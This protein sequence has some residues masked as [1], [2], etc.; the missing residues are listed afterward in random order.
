VIIT[1]NEEQNIRDALES[2]KDFSEIVAIDSFSSDKTV[3][4]SKKY[5]EKVYE[6]ERIDT[7]T[8]L[9]L[10]YFLKYAEAWERE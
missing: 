2:V 10:L 6:E 5:T 7:S 4:I 9:Q 3:D 1:K 8:S